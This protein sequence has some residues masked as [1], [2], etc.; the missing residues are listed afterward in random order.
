MNKLGA[1]QNA[2]NRC[3]AEVTSQEY[4]IP[5]LLKRVAKRRNISLSDR[6]IE[7]LSVGIQDAKDD[8]I[9]L[10]LDLPCALGS[11]EDEV[12]ASL[13]GLVDDLVFAITDLQGEMTDAVSKA[14]PEALTEVAE[15]IASRI[16][17]LTHEHLQDLKNVHDG[18]VASVLRLWG[19][20]INQL[21]LL[22]H[23]VLEWSC[24]AWEQRLGTYT[25]PNTAFALHR[26]IERAYETTGEIISLVREGY[27]DGAL[28]RWR[29]LHEVCVTAMFLAHRSD[30]CALMYLSHHCVEE[31]RLLEV[32]KSSGTAHS[33]NAQLDRY[34]SDLRVKVAAL[35][36]QF[37]AA[38]VRDYGWATVELGRKKTTFR[39]LES[40]VGLETLRRGYQK[41]NSTVHGGAL[42]TLTR[43]SL[44]PGAIDGDE[45]PPA[46]GC[47]V[48]VQYASASLSMMVTE[49]CLEAADADLVTMGMVVHH[50]AIKIRD[51]VE[52][53]QQNLAG[54][55]PRAKLLSRIAA[56]REARTKRVGRK[57]RR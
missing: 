4:L 54:N 55:S 49:L 24:M 53:V 3:L 51:Q 12:Q 18:R 36:K 34:T 25:N 20:A 46:Y 14:I 8:L 43:V 23:M 27:A 16:S 35:S 37:G 11:T 9:H 13:Q 47:E 6:E 1:I 5:L 52:R 42:A 40:Q 41:A 39:D 48:A 31:L 32:D 21:D 7:C 50:Q 17:D 30:R 57:P 56:Q 28:A 26:L 29:S 33:V 10:D 2:L 38:F 15:Q 22:R 45:A 44:G 19:S